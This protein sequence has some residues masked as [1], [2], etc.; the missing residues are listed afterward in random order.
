MAVPALLGL[1]LSLPAAARVTCCDVD[2]RRTCGDPAPPQCLDKA[3]TVFNKGG[4]AKEVEAPMT[5]E[6][7]AAREAE[8]ERRKEEERKA[9]EQARKDQALLASYTNAGEIDK[10]RD[11]AIAEIER[12][13]TQ[14]QNRLEAAL[15]KQ[16]KLEGE[17]EF[18]QKKPLP[19]QLEAQ[20]KDNDSEIAA[21]QKALKE[22]DA[23]IEAVKARFET[24]K[25][26]FVKLSG[27]K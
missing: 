14:A 10:A 25:A 3:K 8:E 18:Y 6:Q 26:R 4:V 11:R 13:A 22:K 12:N 9:A 17:K 16:K 27:R 2:G 23:D 21:Q 24:D 15:K 5:A 7:R 20:I 19:A 1:F